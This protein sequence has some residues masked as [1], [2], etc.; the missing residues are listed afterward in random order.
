M[1]VGAWIRLDLPDHPSVIAFSYVDHEAGFSAQGWKV[2]DSALDPSSRVIVRLPMPEVSWRRLEVD[3]IRALGLECPPPWVAEFYGHQ[4]AAGTLWGAWREHPKLK[5]RFLPDYPDD[6]QV[7]VH[8]GGPRITRNPPEAVWVSVTGME[9]ETFRGR[10]LN[11][12]HHL[13]SVRPGSEIKFVVADGAEFPVMVTDRYL[14][15]RGDWV[16]HP[17]R[18][19]GFSELF[20]AP[21][22]LMRVVFPDMPHDAQMTM[23]TAFCPFCGGAQGVESRGNPVP[24]GENA[25]PPGI[26]AKRP[27]WR[28][29]AK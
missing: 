22:E 8:D 20:D 27:W 1:P 26:P 24:D 19:C 2:L 17:C 3:E 10:V 15:E 13:Q 9:G 14:G 18:G 29:W 7:F 12:P 5:G 25:E 28:F 23:F 16:I 6:L 21:S 4:P 11:Q